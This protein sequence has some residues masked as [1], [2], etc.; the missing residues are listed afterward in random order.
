MNECEYNAIEVVRLA[1][2]IWNRQF[3]DDV[4]NWDAAMNA[5]GAI[6]AAQLQANEIEA[7]KDAL[8]EKLEEVQ[9]TLFNSLKGK[10]E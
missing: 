7:L 9:E 6:Y 3:S 10:E 2:A 8:W 4:N 1:D 5:A